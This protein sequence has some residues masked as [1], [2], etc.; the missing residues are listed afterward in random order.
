MLWAERCPPRCAPRPAPPGG[1]H[2]HLAHLAAALCTPGPR[3]S[4]SPPHLLSCFEARL[5]GGRCGREAQVTPS[6]PVADLTS[7]C[8]GA[9][10][11][12][13][14]GLR[15][16]ACHLEGD[17]GWVRP[18]QRSLSR[19][20]PLV[21]PGAAFL[22]GG[23]VNPVAQVGVKRSASGRGG[24]LLLAWRSDRI[25]WVPLEVVVVEVEV[26]VVVVVRTIP[27]G[28]EGVR[29]QWCGRRC[30]ARG[31]AAHAVSSTRHLAACSCWR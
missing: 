7:A 12:C 4:A 8:E 17:A 24:S 27:A 18:S 6:T 1:P 26:V 19:P 23:A 5:R 28:K 29:L 22:Q 3:P 9:V 20:R 10:C 11:V 21:V 2:A 25:G 13:V 16:L 15:S 30:A 31:R 14:C